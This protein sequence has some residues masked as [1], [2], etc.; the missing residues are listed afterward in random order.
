MT[1][2]NI[3]KNALVFTSLL[4]INPEIHSEVSLLQLSVVTRI[5]FS[6]GKKDALR[7]SFH[8]SALFTWKERKD[9]LT[10]C[11]TLLIH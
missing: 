3:L 6:Y 9:R 5:G 11:R 8:T 1:L 2:K 10:T 7:F 4:T